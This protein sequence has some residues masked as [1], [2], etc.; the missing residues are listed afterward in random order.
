MYRN[1]ITKYTGTCADCGAE[2][3]TGSK[4]RYYGRGRLYGVDCHEDTAKTSTAPPILAALTGAAAAAGSAYV[5]YAAEF[6]TAPA[7]EVV[8][9][10]PGDMFHNPAA[11]T[12]TVGTM[13]DVCGFVWVDIDNRRRSGAPGA[14]MLREFKSHAAE[15]YGTWRLGEFSLSHSGYDGSWHLGGYGADSVTGGT[16]NGAMSAAE[17]GAGAFVASMAAAGY[18]GLRVESRID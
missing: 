1:L 4:A 9:N 3:P 14:R 17:A 12:R 8:E 6:Y 13:F 16:G 2:L 11:P 7:F 5:N 10:A 18:E 15:D